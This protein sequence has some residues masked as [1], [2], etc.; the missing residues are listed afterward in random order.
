LLIVSVYIGL[1]LRILVAIWNA[2]FGPSYGADLDAMAFHL[3]ALEFAQNPTFDEFIIGWIYSVVLGL[4][5]YVTT[6]S[7]FL[8]NI[9]SC[10]AWWLSAILL[11]KC[12]K[13]LLVKSERQLFLLLIYSLLPSSILFT[14]ITLREAYE[15]LLIN[16]AIFAA[17]KIYLHKADLC[18]FTLLLAVAGFSMLHGALLAFGLI[19]ICATIIIVFVFRN[20]NF[21]LPKFLFSTLF[22]LI[23][24]E[25]GLIFFS[26]I[27]YSLEDGLISAIQTLQSKEVA[28]EA[29]ANYRLDVPISY[30][31]ILIFIP[32]GLLQYLFEPFPWH[33]SSVF[34]IFLFLENILRGW[35]IWMGWRAARSAPLK[36]RRV[37]IFLMILYFIMEI[38]WSIGSSNW[39]TAAR[40]HLPSLGLLLLPVFAFTNIKAKYA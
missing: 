10:A 15:L 31:D 36:Q 26:N 18:W 17:L 39:G 27:S 5:Y 23:T 9:L 22:V 29:R 24:I 16:L 11:I 37:L 20:D 28:I 6:S 34:D 14:S 13:I 38:I 1:F 12:M 32:A 7:L 3:A 21:S 33:F 40:H 30:L 8:G 35:L 25:F 4:C 19:F 2:F